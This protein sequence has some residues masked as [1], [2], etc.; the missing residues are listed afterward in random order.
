MNTRAPTPD[1]LDEE[2]VVRWKAC[3]PDPIKNVSEPSDEI[4]SF[5]APP[6]YIVAKTHP[7][8]DLAPWAGRMPSMKEIVSELDRIRASS[9]GFNQSTQPW[10]IAAVILLD[11]LRLE[12]AATKHGRSPSP[13]EI[14]E[15]AVAETGVKPPTEYK[16]AA[17]DHVRCI[18]A[19]GVV[20]LTQGNIYLVVS[21]KR[22]MSGQI[23]QVVSD[24]GRKATVQ[25]FRFDVVDKSVPVTPIIAKPVAPPAEPPCHLLLHGTP[26]A[27]KKA[28]APHEETPPA[29]IPKV[30]KPKTTKI[31]FE[32]D[33]DAF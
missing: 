11:T 20:F 23:L 27:T 24:T 25:S 12:R 17:G 7:E 3:G 33:E 9:L 26:V 21:A 4:E 5:K 15:M 22:A 29:P 8:V 1:W 16:F 6:V 18:E 13:S 30:A 19:L 14:E 2:E 32:G 10:A 31:T 28:S